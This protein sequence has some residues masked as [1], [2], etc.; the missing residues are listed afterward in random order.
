V[1]PLVYGYGVLAPQRISEGGIDALVGS[2]GVIGADTQGADLVGEA[3]AVDLPPPKSPNAPMI[4]ESNAPM[5]RE[6][7]SPVAVQWSAGL[8]RCVNACRSVAARGNDHVCA[9]SAFRSLMAPSAW[10]PISTSG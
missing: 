9:V 3:L 6:S 7:P 4:R 10:S 1:R 2:S 5:I 8:A